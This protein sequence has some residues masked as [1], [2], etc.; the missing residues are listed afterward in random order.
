MPKSTAVREKL[1]L[2]QAVFV[3]FTP[4]VSFLPVIFRNYNQ[5][6][7]TVRLPSLKRG[8]DTPAW[9]IDPKKLYRF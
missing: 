3:E 9:A 7:G 4:Y 6:E 5:Y 1:R 2:K 8:V